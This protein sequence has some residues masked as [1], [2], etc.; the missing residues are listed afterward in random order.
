MPKP[1]G[2]AAAL[3]MGLAVPHRGMLPLRWRGTLVLVAAAA[4]LSTGLAYAT[5]SVRSAPPPGTW[6]YADGAPPTLTAAPATY[7]H[8]AA[9]GSALAYPAS[10]AARALLGGS[11][12]AIRPRGLSAPLGAPPPQPSIQRAG[13]PPAARAIGSRVAV[14][15]KIVLATSATSTVRGRSFRAATVAPTTGRASGGWRWAAVSWYG[16]GFYGQGTACGLTY[17]RS[18]IGVAH[19]SLPCGARVQFRH[20]GRVV[21]APVIDRGPYVGGRSFD[22]SAGLCRA[23]GHCY[24][25][26]IQWRLP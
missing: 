14:R 11:S 22:L 3:P 21:T 18:V 25:G 23:L 2:S 19:R 20:A 8:A 7:S 9:I 17:T 13:R 5:A 24:T 6:V 1:T 26:R 10:P 12:L 16:P 15:R 4:A